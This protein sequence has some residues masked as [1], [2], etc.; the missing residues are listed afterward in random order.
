M[1]GLRIAV[2]RRSAGMS[3]AQLAQKL[4]ISASAVGMYEQG[5]REPTAEILVELAKIFNV[6][7]DYLLTGRQDDA[8]KQAAETAWMGSLLEADDRL[9]RR[10]GR[11]FSRQELTVLYAAMMLES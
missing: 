8:Q 6:S 7:T 5:R 3:Q 2:L 9:S 11:P 1:I 4:Q 10:R